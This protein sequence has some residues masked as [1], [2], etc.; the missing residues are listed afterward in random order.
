MGTLKAMA[1]SRA[2]VE[3]MV[4]PM[5]SA[6]T[7]VPDFDSYDLSALRLA[8][9]GG[10]PVPL[11]VIDFMQQ[12][13]HA[14]TTSCNN[15]FMQQRGV[16]F[17]EGFGMTETAP[18]VSGLGRRQHHT[19]A[20]SIGGVAM[21]VDARIA[22]ALR[23][24]WFHTGDLGRID[25]RYHGFSSS[26]PGSCGTAGTAPSSTRLRVDPLTRSHLV[27]YAD[28]VSDLQPGPSRVGPNRDPGLPGRA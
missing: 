1:E 19:R 23:G 7:Q 9:G 15:D 13:L 18:M 22:E 24:G 6:L 2:T 20:G 21:H 5:W 11:T 27:R 4:P 8:M 10:A 26:A 17:T 25:A 14:T 3:F 28:S 12:R 16:P